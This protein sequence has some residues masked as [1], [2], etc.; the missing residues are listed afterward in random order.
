MT[1][2][3]ENK[4]QIFDSAIGTELIRKG[5]ENYPTPEILNI[6]AE[7]T[8]ILEQI[9]EDSIYCGSDFITSNSFSANEYQLDKIGLP[10]ID[11]TQ[12]ICKASIEICKK[13]SKGRVKIAG[14]IGPLD[15]HHG[16]E[17]ISYKDICDIYRPQV[18]TL[19]ESGADLLILETF[20]NPDEASAVLEVA[21]QFKIPTILMMVAQRNSRG[22]RNKTIRDFLKVAEKY[23]VN[24][25]GVN[26]APPHIITEYVEDLCNMTDL[27]IIVSPN[28]GTPK[29]ER[30]L[31]RYQLPADT[32]IQEAEQ[33]YNFGVKIFGGCCGTS[34]EH[35]KALADN[36]KHRDPV[37]HIRDDSKLLNIKQ[38]EIPKVEIDKTISDNNIRK[39]FKS[40]SKVIAVEMRFESNCSVEDYI[41]E[42]Q[43]LKQCGCNLFTVP[44]N[45]GA[46][47]GMDSITMAGK[48]QKQ[49]DIAVIFHKSATH[50]NLI[51]LYSS[52]LGAWETD[53][54][55]I[56]A[57][58]GDPPATGNFSRFASRITDIKSSVEFIKLIKMLEEGV[59]VNNQQLKKSR[60]FFRACAFAP[61]K[62]TKAQIEWLN[63]KIIAGAEAAFTQP[64]FTKNSFVKINT[65]IEKDTHG[66]RILNGVFPIMSAKQ[67]KIL[68]LGRIPG[69]LIPENYIEQ[70]SKYSDEDQKK[71]G[72]EQAVNVAQEVFKKNN[73]IYIILP[74]CANRFNIARDII[75][76][77]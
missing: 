57:V 15:I 60:S 53:L 7:G 12:T 75:N 62:N 30:G 27:P 56:L 67:A 16:N 2:L 34:S 74:F 5:I 73:S 72:I 8:D 11:D 13:V 46:N 37:K 25:I 4:I 22:G 42:A 39:M 76:Q 19:I 77:L 47:I 51:S 9:Y 66:I 55:A 71:F 40:N 21:S 28:A 35:I 64:Y 10:D 38:F 50:T 44:D 43:M 45:P 23:N 6:A 20:A 63:R 49:T 18:T 14:S 3:E 68:S 59:C 41:S 17:D 48:L 26:C 29:V 33:W 1:F 31:V 58:S 65:Q 69:I 70:I 32:L 24:V 61:Q 36:F 54:R 52:L